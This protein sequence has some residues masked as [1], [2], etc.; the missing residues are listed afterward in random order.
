MSYISA[1]D[2]EAS[3][4]GFGCGAGCNCGPCR[5]GGALSEWYEKVPVEPKQLSG[6]QCNCGRG[7]FGFA[8]LAEPNPTPLQQQL[9][10]I[11]AALDINPKG[12]YVRGTPARATL[13]AA[14]GGV[15][16]CLAAEVLLELRFGNS[17][18]ARLFK[19]RLHRKT[20]GEM[21]DILKHKVGMCFQALKLATQRDNA[22]PSC[23][24]IDTLTTSICNN[25]RSLC[26][27]AGELDERDGWARCQS[28]IISCRDASR[29][30]KDCS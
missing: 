14:F 25:G 2:S 26:K 17:P 11:K 10:K 4:N 9:A 21:L 15:P 19:Y 3:L 7:Q 12:G 28:A 6:L 22:T 30:S 29:R 5:S 1:S 27:V 18:L 8:G 16:I 24:D 13:D 23:A 20:F